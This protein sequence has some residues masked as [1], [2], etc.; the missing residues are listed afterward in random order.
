MVTED[1]ITVKSAHRARV[2]IQTTHK[3]HPIHSRVLIAKTT[4]IPPQSSARVP[5]QHGRLEKYN[6]HDTRRTYHF[7]SN[8]TG[9]LDHVCTLNTAGVQ[10]D[11]SW[12][13]SINAS[14]EPLI[15]R[16]KQKVGYISDYDGNSYSIIT[17]NQAQAIINCSVCDAG[18]D[19]QDNILLENILA[20]TKNNIQESTEEQ[21][22]QIPPEKQG[23]TKKPTDVEERILENGVHLCNEIPEQA[24]VFKQII[25]KYDIWRDHSI[26][27]LPEEEEIKI[28][29]VDN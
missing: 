28:N 15:L 16:R 21:N 14:D 10:P 4:I 9:I 23:M 25:N 12:V 8:T 24:R 27:P 29:L 22:I 2:P 11:S 17:D 1:Y 18:N 5:V 7:K 19:K 20:I 13:L 3:P 26:I 6:P